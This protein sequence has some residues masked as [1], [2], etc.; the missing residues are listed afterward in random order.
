MRTGTP[1]SEIRGLKSLRRNRSGTNY[2]YT[3]TLPEFPRKNT[4]T[5]RRSNSV[6]NRSSSSSSGSNSGMYRYTTGST[7]FSHSNSQVA[8]KNNKRTPHDEHSNEGI[9]SMHHSLARS[10]I[11]AAGRG[12]VKNEF[13]PFHNPLFQMRYARLVQDDEENPSDR[14]DEYEDGF[15]GLFPGLLIAKHFLRKLM[16]CLI[17]LFLTLCF[18]GFLAVSGE[19][20][21]VSNQHIPQHDAKYASQVNYNHTLVQIN[22]RLNL[23]DSFSNLT[24]PYDRMKET[25]FYLDIKLTGSGI[26]K[27]V[28]SECFQLTMACDKLGLRQPNFNEDELDVFTS[29]YQGYQ[30]KYVNVDIST[31]QGIQ[32]AIAL[33]LTQS[34]LADVISTDMLYEGSKLFKTRSHDNVDYAEISGKKA[35]PIPD[36][37]QKKGRIFTVFVH[38]ILRAI[39]YY[40]YIKEATW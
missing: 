6:G 26:V 31:N 35:W 34:H 4:T 5:Q 12:L 18:L 40:H 39:A 3:R 33:N 25:P 36:G 38:P 17:I 27:R 10:V 23:L 19:L 15:F 7:K 13:C 14:D 24:I 8:Q 9:E 2:S 32:R 28:L 22:E 30:G 1:L 16:K 20:Y 21:N 37:D 29:M 11:S